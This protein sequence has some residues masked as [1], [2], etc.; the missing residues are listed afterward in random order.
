MRQC[1]NR[2][3]RGFTIPP[4]GETAVRV[5]VKPEWRAVAS[6]EILGF[7]VKVFLGTWL[8]ALGLCGAT[9]GSEKALTAVAQVKR[10]PAEE[11]AAARPVALG[12]VVTQ[13]FPE[14]G[15]LALED[16]TAAVY[17]ELGTARTRDLRP[18]QFVLVEGRTMRG[19][20]APAVRAERI[21]IV[22]TASLPAAKPVSWRQIASGGC[23][24][25]YVEVEGVVRSVGPVAP[26]A[27][28]WSATALRLDIGGN[29]VWAFLRVGQPLPPEPLVDSSVRVRGVCLVYSNAHRQ[30]QGS[31]LSLTR[32][33]DLEV[34]EP[35]H[36]DPFDA[37]LQPVGR[38][39]GYSTEPASL[40]R[41]K[42]RGIATLQLPGR[43]YLEE[44]AD[45]ILV[46]TGSAPSIRPGDRV[47]AVG[48]PAAGGFLITLE[49]GLIRVIGHAPPPQARAFAAGRMLARA[50]NAPAVPNAQ[51]VRVEGRVMDR[52]RSASEEMLILGEG[53]VSFTARIERQAGSLRS[54]EPGS[55]VAVTGVCSVE[56][57]D[58]GLP[59]SFDLLMRSPA[60]VTVLHRA[61]WFS[62][63][64]AIRIV[65]T[66]LALLAAVLIWLALLRRRVARQT[67]IIRQQ[68][69]R[70]SALERHYAGLV[71]NASD[72]VYVRNLDGRMLQV[73][74][75]AEEMTGYSR[76]E[77]LG[78]N[79]LDLLA[80]AERERARQELAHL[81]PE[82]RPA[83]AG[84]WR[85]LTKDGRELV[86][87]TKQ[88]FLFENGEPVR[89]EAIGRDVTAR[90]RA[91]AQAI[92]ERDRLEEQLHHSQK[93]ESVGQLAGGVAHDFNNLLTVI[94]GYAQMVLD[95]LPG[96][97]PLRE[98]V[99][100]VS[101]AASR[102]SALTRQLL[103]FSRRERP[104]PGFFSVN[105]LVRDFERML[106]RLIDED[107]ELTLALQART[108]VIRA[109]PGHIEQAL[110]NLVVNARDA[111]PDGGSLLIR[112]GDRHVSA[113]KDGRYGGIPEGEYVELEVSD[114][115]IGMSAE[116][117]ARIFEPFFTTKGQGK[118]TGLGLSMVRD[119]VR[120]SGGAIA[121]RS[122]PGRGSTF[123]ILLPAAEAVPDV[124]EEPVQ[125]AAAS[126]EATVLV[127]EDEPGVRGFIR[128]ILTSHSYTVLEAANGREALAIAE[129]HAGPIHLLLTDVIMPEMGGVTLAERF[130]QLRPGV[131]VVYM[132]GY[133]DRELPIARE[134]LIEKPFIPSTLLRR[135]ETVLATAK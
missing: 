47:E 62:R 56:V 94:S 48:F 19:N 4:S 77:L 81:P 64:T 38:L 79:I 93:L 80:P 126:V 100:E 132:S 125:P 51:L 37:P 22:R 9:S 110:M 28:D 68:F 10:L 83:A 102:A 24:N 87:E 53:D 108:G 89:V 52:S 69:E 33:A 67:G 99:A 97:S 42:V 76:N 117:Q 44:G 71:Q 78:M 120:Q 16:D 43:V 74:R 60:D 61:P 14:W 26:P 119:I 70:E 118:G 63:D 66:L 41:V 40:H 113:D 122:E 96:E 46:H 85:F 23:D 131:P 124:P 130:A 82:E 2:L 116:L 1:R 135:I 101:Q 36:Q 103:L 29:F 107:I 20:F 90:H 105:E 75:G 129:R 92:T 32:A 133:T 123:T 58:R 49:D 17:V 35:A 6:G 59:Q 109:D 88:R 13:L 127:A 114:T 134:A 12:G 34:I 106:S 3:G 128:E 95:Q 7:Y 84:E 55:R 5:R 72:L 54:I 21:R 30:F 104:S 115:G 91:Q 112:T 11:A 31:V 111:M 25:D 57:D 39:F 121:V 65:S 73:N 27:W 15:G 18:G 86:I 50:R 8:A 98:P 45:G